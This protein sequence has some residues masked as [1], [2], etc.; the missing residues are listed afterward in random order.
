M[1][2]LFYWRK[3]MA[4]KTYIAGS[5]VRLHSG[6]VKITKKQHARRQRLLGEYKKNGVYDV[7]SK[8]EFKA[9]EEFGY[10]GDI[11]KSMAEDL[12]ELNARTQAD[13]EASVKEAEEKRK[14]AE[15]DESEKKKASE[16]AEA[17]SLKAERQ[18]KI[19][20]VI[21]GLDEND[22]ALYTE[23]GLPRVDAIES[24]LG[25]DITEDERDAAVDAI[26]SD[27]GESTEETELSSGTEED[28]GE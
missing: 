20:D 23:E 10:D 6:K 2:R 5:V 14:A 27:A 11:P 4:M 18:Q 17:E 15:K 22:D 21:L 24:V 26:E 9:G 16:K 25:E 28:A 7:T 13:K 19:I 12:E 3:E 1:G 8:I